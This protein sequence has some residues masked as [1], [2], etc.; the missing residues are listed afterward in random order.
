[1]WLI[2]EEND[3]NWYDIVEMTTD[4]IEARTDAMKLS[5]TKNK[6]HWVCYM[7]W[8]D[9][10]EKKVKQ[11]TMTSPILPRTTRMEDTTW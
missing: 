5:H 9:E 3:K 7:D 2:I 10:Y 4:E 6:P 8:N 1:M 11:S